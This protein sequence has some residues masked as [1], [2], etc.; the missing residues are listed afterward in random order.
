LDAAVDSKRPAA[1][2]KP[3]EQGLEDVEQFCMGNLNNLSSEEQS[4]I[5][6]RS[7]KKSAEFSVRSLHRGNLSKSSAFAF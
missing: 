4:E 1:G 2:F 6:H 7:M 3:A 5:F